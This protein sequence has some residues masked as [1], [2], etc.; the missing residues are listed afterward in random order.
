MLQVRDIVLSYL[1]LGFVSVVL[2]CAL[3]SASHGFQVETSGAK[4]VAGEDR[5]QLSEGKAADRADRGTEI[6]IP[7]LGTLGVLPKLDFGLELLYGEGDQS[8]TE[9]RLEEQDS[10]GLQI[11]G[12]LKHRF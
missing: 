11:K 5:A 3:T 4:P 6:A 7:G 12:T 8:P 9:R 1:R 2:S 10:E